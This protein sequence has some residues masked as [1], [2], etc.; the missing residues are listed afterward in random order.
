MIHA[1]G[2]G[3]GYIPTLVKHVA[4]PYCAMMVAA[5]TPRI[6]RQERGFTASARGRRGA[7]PKHKVIQVAV[8][9]T[10]RSI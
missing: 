6:R 3:V 8:E 2:T 9:N 10:F 5:S 7:E 1:I 4:D